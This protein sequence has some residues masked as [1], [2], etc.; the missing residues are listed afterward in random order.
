MEF[1]VV[2]LTDDTVVECR[3]YDQRLA[4]NRGKDIA[5]S[6]RIR[7]LLTAD[8]GFECSSPDFIKVA[9]GMVDSALC[10]ALIIELLGNVLAIRGPV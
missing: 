8:P 4:G 9:L 6:M 10:S 7:N 3:S 2:L 1:N 5:Q